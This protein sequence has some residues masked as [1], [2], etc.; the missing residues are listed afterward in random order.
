MDRRRLGGSI[1][2]LV[3]REF[4]ARGFMAAFTERTGGVSRGPFGSL[5]LGFDTGDD[6]ARVAQNRER[7]AGALACGPFAV[8]RQ[9]HGSSVLRIGRARAGR[10]FLEGPERL[11][12]ADALGTK[13]RSSAVAV[14]AA[15]CLP[16]ALC[17]PGENRLVVAHA[18][19]RGLAAGLLERVTHAFARPKEVW[20]A[21]G[22]AI[23]PCHYEVGP[24][25]VAELGRGSSRPK[26]IRTGGRL[27]VDLVATAG[28]R[29]REAGIRRIEK[30]G[31]CTACLPERFFS[32]RRDGRTGRQA[33]VGGTVNDVAYVA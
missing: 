24:E 10:G 29:L 15:D 7:I 2:V 14:L 5:N 32:H 31:L 33:L 16:I 4:E 13:G 3:S 17:S 28:S 11:Q 12:A 18:G 22:P 1:Q 20:A 23:G 27:F 25:V 26:V 30:A 8:A 9:I 21:I 19:W 6:S